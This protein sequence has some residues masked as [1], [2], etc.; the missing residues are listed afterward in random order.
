MPLPGGSPC[1]SS[2]VR[3]PH[4]LHTVGAG[5]SLLMSIFRSVVVDVLMSIFRSV[6]VDVLKSIFRSVVVDVLL[7]HMVYQVFGSCEVYSLE[8]LLKRSTVTVWPGDLSEEAAVRPRGDYLECADTDAVRTSHKSKD[9]ELRDKFV[10]L[11]QA[12][13]QGLPHSEGT[14]E[15]AVHVQVAGSSIDTAESG[16][17][18]VGR[19]AEGEVRGEEEEREGRVGGQREEGDG[20]NEIPKEKPRAEDVDRDL[21][22]L[23]AK[24]LMSFK[25]KEDLKRHLREEDLERHL[26]EEDLREEDLKRH[27]REEDLERHLRE[28][29][30]KRHLREEDLKRHLR[31]EDLKRH[32]REE[33]LR[34]EDLK[35]HLREEDL[36]RHL[37]EE[38]L[39]RHLREEDLERHLRE[40]DLKRHL[41]EEDLK[42]HLREEDLERHLREEGLERHLRELFAA[43]KTITAKENLLLSLRWE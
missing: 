36:E 6:V 24:G 18:V 5:T 3:V 35:R 10:H 9:T 43:T 14:T 12:P 42:R 7:R 32:L 27:L 17:T 38:G 26:R 2:T 30:L 11:L 23:I 22:A 20:Q 16:D 25:R 29:D 33:H 19:A 1:H 40:E 21:K 8:E 4:I 37:R 31:E 34:E 41:R 39:K 13:S 15:E 28:E